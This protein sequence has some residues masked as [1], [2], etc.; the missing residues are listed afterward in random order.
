MG[1]YCDDADSAANTASAITVPANGS[2][3]FWI[4]PRNLG[5]TTRILG[6]DDAFEG[7]FDGTTLYHEWTQ[8]G[9]GG[10]V[11]G[12]FANDTLYHVVCTW[13]GTTEVGEAY[14]DGAFVTSG[15]GYNDNPSSGILSLNSRAGSGELVSEFYDVRIYNRVLSAAEI[16]TMFNARGADGICDGMLHRWKLD[17]LAPGATLGTNGAKDEGSSQIPFTTGAATATYVYNAPIVGRRRV[18]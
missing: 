5:G 9:G 16:Q 12:T 10:E 8:S 14:L 18:A 1:L 4:I 11:V 2:L 6:F 13:N 3:C 7:R 17:E 15:S